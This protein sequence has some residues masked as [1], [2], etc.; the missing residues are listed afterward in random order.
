MSSNLA[1]TYPANGSLRM[2]NMFPYRRYT[3]DNIGI[4]DMMD[5][6]PDVAAMGYNAVWLNPFQLS[7][8]MSHEHPDKSMV[9]GMCQE[10]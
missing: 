7:G 2:Y 1:P 5:Y 3:S 8:T 10:K 6:L 4:Q 9:T